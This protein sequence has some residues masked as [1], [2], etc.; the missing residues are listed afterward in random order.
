M[1]RVV[2]TG[3]AGFIGFH[4][5]KKLLEKNWEVIGIDNLNDYYD[6]NLKQA[7][8][9]ILKSSNNFKFHKI[10]ICEFDKL[11]EAVADCKYIIHLAAQAGVR[12]SLE[13][14]FTYIQSNIVGHLN[15]LE[16]CRGISGFE[17]L[18]YAS[19]SSVYG[20]NEKIPFS[21]NDSVVKPASLYAATKISDELMTETYN[22]LYEIN[23]IGLR[24]FTVYG[25][26]GRPDMAP[27]KFTKSIF[28]NE[29]IDVYNNG[30]MRRD[31]TYIDDVVNGV[32]ASL[33]KN[34]KGHKIYNLGNNKPENLMDFVKLI[35]K[36]SGKNAEI[37]MLP[38]QPGDI[39]ETFADISEAASDLEYTP[40]T[41][42]E[43]GI[44]KTV[45][46]YRQ[47]YQIA[48]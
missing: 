15:V 14:P 26:Y 45:E 2:V 7:R 5:A 37:N 6:V 24:F 46:W 32:I 23:A 42:L 38:I 41:S 18:I 20:R 11:K 47:F 43:E 36:Y 19:S 3:A 17:K 44:K 28:N 10:D 48:S 22:Y 29:T 25:E 21:V 8:L 27:F 40:K 34:I 4:V 35:E 16:V 1:Q 12:Y 31:F 9:N 30:D 39:K 13:N 33:E